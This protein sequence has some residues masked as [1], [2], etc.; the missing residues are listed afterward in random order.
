[1]GFEVA[2]RAGSA[3]HLNQVYLGHT[4][5]IA[6]SVRPVIARGETAVIRAGSLLNIEPGIFVPGLGS[7]GVENTLYVTDQGAEAINNRGVELHVV[8]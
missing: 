7:A 4:T 8:A 3:D 5:G 1:M 2:A 6:T